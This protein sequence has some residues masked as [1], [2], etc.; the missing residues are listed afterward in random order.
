[1]K[2]DLGEIKKVK[3]RKHWPNEQSDF[4]PWLAEEEHIKKL[5]DAI[6]LELEVENIE[7]AVGPYSADILA[8][9]VGTGSYVVIENQ[10]GK[11][12]HDHLGKLITYGS[13]LDA[14]AIVWLAEEFTEQHHRALDWLN[15]HTEDELGFFGVVLE[16]WQIDDSRPAIRFNVVSRPASAGS[17][18]AITKASQ[19]MSETKKLQLE[20]W[21]LFAKRLKERKV[22]SST[23]TPSPR[24]WFNVSLGHSGFSLSNIANTFDNRIGIRLYMRSNVA[25][26][27]LVQLEQQRAEIEE[28]IGE[29]LS[30]NPN[31]KNR[32][33]IIAL[34]RDCILSDREAWPGHVD[35]L[36]DQV[37]KFKKTFGPRI[38]KLDLSGDRENGNYG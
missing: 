33:K 28:E 30:W 27:A 32:D 17:K 29:K 34:H 15:D 22:V 18:A 19:G 31:P 37:A 12:N 26:Q 3:V 7:V 14:S 1:M 5:G 21:T 16:L 2:Q 8:K 9:D 24:Y 20:F 4:T 38:K 6:G 25:E 23:Q 36:V 13:V 10:F 35:W 11:T